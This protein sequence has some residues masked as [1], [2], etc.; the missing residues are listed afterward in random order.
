M[1][2]E[3]IVKLG[4]QKTLEASGASI[5][6]NT[7]AQANDA[8]YSIATDGAYYPDARFVL[9]GAFATA[10]ADRDFCDSAHGKHHVGPL[11][12]TAKYRRHG[13]RRRPRD[14]AASS[15]HRRVCGQ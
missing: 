1:S 6:N 14:D 5:A 8:D 9:T 15:I 7:L 4:T 3:A 11:C 10:R 2:N 12:P 13:R